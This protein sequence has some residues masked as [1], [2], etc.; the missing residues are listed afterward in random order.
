[1]SEVILKG[2]VNMG[3]TTNQGFSTDVE[4]FGILKPV[5]GNSYRRIP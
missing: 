2:T 4:S 5:L 3:R 1:M